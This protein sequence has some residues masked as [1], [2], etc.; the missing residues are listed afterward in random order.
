MGPNVYIDTRRSI[1]SPS[2]SFPSQPH[3]KQP[4]PPITIPPIMLH[5]HLL[6]ALQLSSPGDNLAVLVPPDADGVPV[7][8]IESIPAFTAL[9]YYFNI[10]E[11]APQAIARRQRDGEALIESLEKNEAF[12]R[13][14]NGTYHYSFLNHQTL[15]PGFG[16][17]SVGGHRA[18]T[19]RSI[20][21]LHY[22]LLL[23]T[24]VT[25][26]STRF[27]API[28]TM[29]S[30]LPAGPHQALV[31]LA[32]PG[33]AL[34]VVCDAAFGFGSIDPF[35]PVIGIKSRGRRDAET[36]F[37][38]KRQSLQS[39]QQQHHRNPHHTQN[40]VQNCFLDAE[41]VPPGSTLI[42]RI[43]L[44]DVVDYGEDGDG[45]MDQKE[46]SSD[47]IMTTTGTETRKSEHD[48]DNHLIPSKPS[49]TPNP[50]TNPNHPY[51][52]YYK[53]IEP[54]EIRFDPLDPT[55]LD[56]RVLPLLRPDLFAAALVAATKSNKVDI[57]EI[58]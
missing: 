41:R 28:T 17:E 35:C 49:S 45:D 18:L 4:P 54:A 39:P 55:Q 38:W 15:G 14:P 9:Q 16:N 47:I 29:P 46:P 34:M 43:E 32:H 10:V 24:G 51:H 30:L 40:G 23:S 13:A 26:V 44:V 53:M 33:D 21:R 42:Y 19:S 57:D 5:P 36:H 50:L 8:N 12:R 3:H 22:D 31:D 27:K 1:A 7:I 58:G 20:V 25:V 6:Q 56:H 37:H 48:K 11:T 52:Q 2:S